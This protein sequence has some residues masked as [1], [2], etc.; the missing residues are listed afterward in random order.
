MP[1]PVNRRRLAAL[2]TEQ[3]N[4]RT[5]H[6]DQMTVAQILAAIHREDRRVA[7]AVF[8]QRATI[9]AAVEQIVAS[10]QRGGRLIYV[11]AGTSGRLGVLDASEIP[12]TFNVPPRRVAGL[13]A[14]GKR[15]LY[16]AAEG[17]ED[18]A[19]QGERDLARLKVGPADTVVGIAA[20]GRTPYTVG[21][22][23]YARRR[24]AATVGV[25]CVRGS[26]A[27]REAAIAIEAVT[28]PEVIAGSTRM[29]A[30]TAQKL[31]L[32]M[33]ST[34]AMIRLG[35]VHD[36]LMINVRATNAKLAARAERILMAITGLPATAARRRL[37][38]SGGDL[39]KAIEQWAGER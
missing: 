17:A 27:G 13:I 19:R 14:G 18:D 31:I 15:A 28:G 29:K 20:S 23:R 2:P 25:A 11:G 39:K 33:L 30:G 34:A 21:A 10:F 36:N 38:A 6:L 9:G 8:R 7:D 24:G 26:E 32:N 4:P 37:G 5:R 22:L 35:Y 3:I 12:P 1:K 16:S